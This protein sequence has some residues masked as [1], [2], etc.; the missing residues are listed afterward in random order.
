M[1]DPGN[2]IGD[3]G[4][5]ALA[6]AL[7]ELKQLETLYLSSK[8]VLGRWASVSVGPWSGLW[9]CVWRMYVCVHRALSTN[10]TTPAF[11]STAMNANV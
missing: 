9:M 6:E 7:K 8:C 5:K 4:A 2:Q 1:A 3:E 10:L 11:T